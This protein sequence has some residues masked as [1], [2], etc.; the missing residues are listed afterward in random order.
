MTV[1][2][3]N[4]YEAQ[5]ADGMTKHTQLALKP[6]WEYLQ[7]NRLGAKGVGMSKIKKVVDSKLQKAY[8]AGKITT[9]TLTFEYLEHLAR[10]ANIELTGTPG[11]NPYRLHY[12][13]FVREEPFVQEAI[14]AAYCTFLPN[15]NF[16]SRRNSCP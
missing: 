12:G 7:T 6:L 3:Q 16:K 5:S 10:S 2:E 1:H 15:R 13:K 9:N 11:T 4:V 14:Q 8:A